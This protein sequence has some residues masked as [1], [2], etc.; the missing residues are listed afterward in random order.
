MAPTRW[1][2]FMDILFLQERMSRLFDEALGRFKGCSAVPGATWFPPVD[3]YETDEQIIL[4]A[5]IPG[6]DA[7]HVT[8]EIEGNSLTLRGERKHAKNLKEENY[9]RMERF[10][11]QFCRVFNLPMAVDKTA[12]TAQF[13]DGVLKVTVP[14]IKEEFLDAVK[15]PVL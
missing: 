3:I 1:N 13:N 2:P 14:K 15:V 6:I 4:K 8:I 9:H 7:R 11:G 12:I 5:E 10:Y